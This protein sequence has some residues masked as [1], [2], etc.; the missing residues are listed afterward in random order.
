MPPQIQ[1]LDFKSISNSAL[2][3]LLYFLQTWS[4]PEKMGTPGDTWLNML[5]IILY[6]CTVSTTVG[7]WVSIVGV[8][9]I[10]GLDSLG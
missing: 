5:R 2:I 7:N 4:Y 6:F 3:Y 8:W 9:K 10:Q 1:Y